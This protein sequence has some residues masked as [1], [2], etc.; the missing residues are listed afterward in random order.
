MDRLERVQIRVRKVIRGLGTS[1]NR[2]GWENWVWMA[3]EKEGLGETLS[4]CPRV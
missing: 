4:P 1:H 2:K 3:L